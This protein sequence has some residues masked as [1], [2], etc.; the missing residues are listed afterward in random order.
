MNTA[1]TPEAL[2]EIVHVGPG[3]PVEDMLAI[4]RRDGVLIVDGL[5]DE[6]TVAALRSELQG[7]VERAATHDGFLGGQNRAGGRPHRRGPGLPA[8]GECTP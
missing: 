8:A 4:Y 2:H 3:T 5:A 1:V 7:P 6:D